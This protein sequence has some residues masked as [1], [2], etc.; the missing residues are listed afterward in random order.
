MNDCGRITESSFRRGLDDLTRVLTSFN[1]LYISHPEVN[2][3]AFLYKDPTD[4]ERILWRQF[5]EDVEEGRPECIIYLL[6]RIY[7]GK[8]ESSRLCKRLY[9]PSW[10]WTRAPHS[11]NRSDLMSTF[12]LTATVYLM[13][14]YAELLS[15]Q[16]HNL[17][18]APSAKSQLSKMS[19][20]PTGNVE[21]LVVLIPIKILIYLIKFMFINN[22]IF[23]ILSNL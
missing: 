17:V 13:S 6:V 7:G 20:C 9:T 18:K 2:A 19:L 11:S 8:A 23:I 12:Q 22:L 3:L 4:T 16:T 15:L 14:L 5:C 21:K 10:A 1:K